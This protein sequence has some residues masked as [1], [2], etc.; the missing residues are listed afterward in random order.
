MR[1]G[2]ASTSTHKSTILLLFERGGKQRRSLS[3]SFLLFSCFSF[4][5]EGEAADRK[6]RSLSPPA[7]TFVPPKLNE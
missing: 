6:E 7:R 5:V 4:L 3:F 1:G 2:E